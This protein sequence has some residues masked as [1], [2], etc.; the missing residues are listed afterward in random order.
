V[1]DRLAQLL[2]KST[3]VQDSLMIE[4]ELNRVAGEIDRLEGR[5][6]Y[7]RDR[8]AFSTLTVS[9]A[10]RRTDSPPPSVRLPF[11]WL[12]V[13]GLSQLLSL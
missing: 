11:S 8:A 10:N 12:R 7:L 9:F 6:K 13:G 3:T 2:A 4:R 1:R 5:L